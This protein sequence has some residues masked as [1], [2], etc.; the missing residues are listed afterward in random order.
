VLMIVDP[1]SA[2]E[3]ATLFGNPKRTQPA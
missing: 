2:E 1:E 3:L